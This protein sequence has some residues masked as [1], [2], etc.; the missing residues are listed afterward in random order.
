MNNISV[1]TNDLY[2]IDEENKNDL[3]EENEISNLK[4]EVLELLKRFSNVLKNKDNLSEENKND[5]FYFLKE[6]ISENNFDLSEDNFRKKGLP[7]LKL[8]SDNKLLN[9]K[10]FLSKLKQLLEEYYKVL[11]EN[12]YLS[13]SIKQLEEK[14]NYLTKKI[15]QKEEKIT[16]LEEENNYLT[17]KITQKEEEITQK[18]EKSKRIIESLKLNIF[19]SDYSKNLNNKENY[20]NTDVE[21]FNESFIPRSVS[22]NTSRDI[23]SCDLTRSR[24]EESYL[25]K[26]NNS[27]LTVSSNTFTKNNL[28]YISFNYLSKNKDSPPLN[29]KFYVRE[30]SHYY[31]NESIKVR[32][33][34]IEINNSNITASYIK[35]NSKTFISLDSERFYNLNKLCI[36]KAFKNQNYRNYNINP[37]F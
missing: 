17:K 36:Q 19:L 7:F 32:G 3:S 27:F 10:D 24:S 15:T 31:I 16:Q 37:N 9:L 11:N 5:H 12:D 4:W 33:K 1:D 18:E 8:S 34:Y 28:Q 20:N 13:K 30:N 26:N 21:S 25:Q 6:F 35:N 14:N 23:I 29:Y 2:L 22:T